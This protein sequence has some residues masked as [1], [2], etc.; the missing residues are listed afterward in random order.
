MKRARIAIAAGLIFASAPII[1]LVTSGAAHAQGNTRKVST[2]GSDTG[3][4]RTS[5][6]ATINYA[7]SQA[8]PYDTVSVAAGTYHQTVDI[9][10]PVQ[11]IGAGPTK[12]TL[13]G[14]GLDPSLGTDNPYGVVY[15]GTSHG[16][17]EVHGFKIT[18]PAPYAY[19]SGE[20]MVVALRDTLS[21]D[22]VTID[23][24]VLTEGNSDG[25]ASTDFPIGLD[26]FVNSA[27]TI[28][29][30]NQI[31]GTFQ[32]ALLEDNGPVH[33]KANTLSSLI[34]GTDNS[35]S[36]PTVYPA[37]GAFFLS[38]L[39]EAITGQQVVS[40]TLKSYGGF[41]LIMEAGY[42]N[43][44]CSSTPCNGSLYGNFTSNS[45]TLSPG[46]A[47]TYG[48]IFRAEFAGNVL[49]AAAKNNHGSVVAPTTPEIVQAQNGAS[50]TV[51]ESDNSL[52]ASSSRAA[53][54]H[55]PHSGGLHIP[56]WGT[57]R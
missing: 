17:V 18:N 12:T 14:T 51:V 50:I 20:P 22:K 49:G 27:Q 41:G 54:V 25:N 56:R 7:L 29:T 8:L 11:L 4:C 43:G 32:G 1:A 57:S 53:S 28:I 40:N 55:A 9:E 44:N 5:P 46:V 24:N 3:N 2:T 26:T 19:T 39:A 16:A 52:P 6:C 48:L 30:N 38:D 36:P 31:S 21:T 23:G 34:S 33:F 10:K 42:N 47:G 45:V 13:D 37:E 15:V 35:T